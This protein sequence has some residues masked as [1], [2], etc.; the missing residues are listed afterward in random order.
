MTDGGD[1]FERA[2]AA[3]RE[4]EGLRARL[5][6]ATTYADQTTARVELARDA[7]VREERDVQRLEGLS[8]SRILSGLRGA[9]ATDLEREQAERDAARYAVA[10]A[11][12]REELA[13]RDV[14]AIQQR[15]DALGDVEGEYAAARDDREAWSRANDPERGD[16]LTE[17][18]ERRGLLLAEDTEGREAFDAG[19]AARGHL[20]EALDLL[21]SAGSWSTWDTFGGGGMLTDMIK[22]DRLD[23]V[24]EA[25]RRADVALGRFTRELADLR[26]AG[27]EV[28][29]LGPMTQVFDV[30]FDNIF[31]DL[32]VRSRIQDA[33]VR[34]GAALH[35]VEA[36]MDR[37]SARG[38]EIAAELD[39]LA[40]RREELL[41]N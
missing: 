12:T 2:A 32:R 27:V 20:L 31:T 34:V 10:D 3:R 39:E 35:G 38:R 25:L 15:L 13:W 30:F 23:K 14:E 37:L 11:G 17:V 1:R 6:A 41:V 8:W 18:A 5:K 40:R 36:T 16:R 21:R 22:Y 4:A 19:A 7:L 28:L 29:D 9:H 24:T 26:I 33:E